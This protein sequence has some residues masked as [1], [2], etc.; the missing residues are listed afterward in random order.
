[1]LWLVLVRG[2]MMLEVLVCHESEHQ[3][4]EESVCLCFHTSDTA[5]HGFYALN[6]SHDDMKKPEYKRYGTLETPH[7][8]ILI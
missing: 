6:I 3:P 8:V 7:K 1:M 2:K 4:F 5:C